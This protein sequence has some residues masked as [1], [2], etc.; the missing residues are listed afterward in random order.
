VLFLQ[1]K[2]AL[3]SLPFLIWELTGGGIQ[4]VVVVG[5]GLGILMERIV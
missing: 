3:A 5:C 1:Q 4:K 2:Q